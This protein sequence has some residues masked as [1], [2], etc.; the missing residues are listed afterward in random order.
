MKK[1]FVLLWFAVGGVL[2][3][4][5]VYLPTLSKYRDLKLQQDDLDKQVQ[6]L[7]SDIEEIREERDLLKNDV[8]YL[9]KVIR[10]EMGLVKP[11]EI[12]YKFVPDKDKKVTPAPAASMSPSPSVSPVPSPSASSS[13]LTVEAKPV[14]A[15]KPLLK[16]KSSAK[17]KLP[18]KKTASAQ[19]PQ[20]PRRETR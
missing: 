10:D 14:A 16:P 12:V 3:F 7:T 13:G 1:P 5:W 19:E 20:Y 18:A 15:K 2:I 8:E 11:G 17:P 9:E 4:S 6:K